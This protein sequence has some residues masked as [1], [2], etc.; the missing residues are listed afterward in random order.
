MPLISFNLI[1]LGCALRDV[2]KLIN[3]DVIYVLQQKAIH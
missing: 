1:K 3:V 2:E